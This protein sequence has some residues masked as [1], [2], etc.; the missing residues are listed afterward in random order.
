MNLKLT[1]RLCILI[2]NDKYSVL[3]EKID[4]FLENFDSANNKE[5]FTEIKIQEFSTQ[6]IIKSEN[7]QNAQECM[8]SL[9][10]LLFKG[11][12]YPSVKLI[13]EGKKEDLLFIE[14]AMI[15]IQ[16]NRETLKITIEM[17]H[18][19]YIEVK[20]QIMIYGAESDIDSAIEELDILLVSTP[21]QSEKISM[22][23]I[24]V[25]KLMKSEEFL[26]FPKKKD[27]V[28]IFNQLQ[29][30]LEIK[31]NNPIHEEKIKS[32]ISLPKF[33]INGENQKFCSI[34]L[35]QPNNAYV[36][37][38]G[39]ASCKTCLEN[40]IS[41]FIQ[42]G[43][44]FPITTSCCDVEMPIFD[45]MKILPKSM[46]KKLIDQA[47]NHFVLVNDTQYL[48]CPNP[49]CSQVFSE[50]SLKMCGF[51]DICC[52]LVSKKNFKKKSISGENFKLNNLNLDDSFKFYEENEIG[53]DF[54]DENK[55]EDFE[56]S[57]KDLVKS[58]L[59]NKN[60][61]KCNVCESYWWKDGGSDH[62]TCQ[63]CDSHFCYRCEKVFIRR[64]KNIT[65]EESNLI[66]Q[67]IKDPRNCKKIINY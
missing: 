56:D 55:K 16:K 45:I 66:Y 60:L 12:I 40:Q 65:K 5:I 54:N 9:R 31:T 52:E 28:W 61:A 32:L 53:L 39:H 38:C 64:K 41:A 49:N 46:H 26:Q 33:K 11:R 15:F 17:K 43:N 23:G 30:N 3:R 7:L 51:C 6:I 4:N 1:F 21:E 58:F 36:L 57:T 25:S 37:I 19:V 44:K 48:K 14:N 62:M 50:E 35:S 67:H 47:M 13:K 22:K 8:K 63:T 20:S 34:C 27:L 24:N 42:K 10:K 2:E 18:K 29:K 59:M